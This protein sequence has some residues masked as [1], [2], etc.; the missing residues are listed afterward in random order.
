MESEFIGGH[1]MSFDDFLDSLT[2]PKETEK[3][4]QS[5]KRKQESTDQLDSLTEERGS[6]DVIE[7]KGI[8]ILIVF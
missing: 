6:K 4:S 8:I 7:T 3:N 1:D 5:L 2:A